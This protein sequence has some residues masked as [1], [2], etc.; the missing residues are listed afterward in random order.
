MNKGI[1]S[2]HERRSI[3]KYQDKRVPKEYIDQ[4]LE[5]ARAAPSA[6][7]RQPWKYIVFGG[8]YKEELLMAMENGLKREERGITNLP[9]S[10]YGIP[11]ARNTLRIMREAPIIIMI[12]NTN[13]RSPFLPVD[14]DGRIAEICDTLS[15]GASVEN[16][17]LA[18]EE[19]GLGTLWVA[20]TCFAYQE[21]V[22]YL[23]TK[24]QLVGAIVVGYA[25]E[26]PPQR[27]R[28]RLEEIVEY[29]W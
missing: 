20:N 12:L 18:A 2:I 14:N 16:M 15:I 6:K 21:M 24:D 3:R 22:S 7:N 1:R 8:K 17:L 4:I 26:K 28:K 23:D 10:R 9:K 27:P 25:D 29:R 13:A 11:D 19:L 5:A